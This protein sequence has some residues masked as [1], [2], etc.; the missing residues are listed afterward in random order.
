MDAKVVE[1]FRRQHHGRHAFEGIGWLLLF[2]AVSFVL[3]CAGLRALLRLC[4]EWL[5]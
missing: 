2:V 3:T 1:L 5:L 4:T